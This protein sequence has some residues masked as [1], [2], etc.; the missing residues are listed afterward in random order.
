M[1]DPGAI[2]YQPLMAMQNALRTVFKASFRDPV[3][4][5]AFLLLVVAAVAV[6]LVTSVT[7]VLFGPFLYFAFLAQRVS[8]YKNN[9]WQSFAQ[10]NGWPLD[11][12]TPPA[13]LIPPSMWFGHNRSFSPVIQAQ[14]GQTACDLFTYNTTTGGGRSQ[15]THYYTLAR[16]SLPEPLPHMLLLSKKAG[17]DLQRDLANKQDLPL[18]GD[19]DDYFKLQIEQGQ[20]ID[21]LTLITP[22]VMQTLVQFNQ[23]ED[24]EILGNDLYFILNRDRRDFHDLESL[25]QSALA[26]SQQI[27]QNISLE[28]GPSEGPVTPATSPTEPELV[29]PA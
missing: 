19:F 8:K 1:S 6:G 4:I 20:Q 23:A 21:A 3:G 2:N 29:S 13:Q 15:Q 27:I 9:I 24:I 16:I 22:D 17:A 14:L 12:T 5:L 11:T 7:V 10:A 28:H 18:E 25:I 26:L